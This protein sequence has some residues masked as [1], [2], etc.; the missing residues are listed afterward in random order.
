MTDGILVR[1]KRHLGTNETAPLFEGVPFGDDGPR[2]R[3]VLTTKVGNM[4]GVAQK[5]F[6]F[7]TFNALLTIFFCNIRNMYKLIIF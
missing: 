2:E 4:R 3:H 6:K 7:F 5:S 1:T